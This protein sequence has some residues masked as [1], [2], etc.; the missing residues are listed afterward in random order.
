VSD[1]LQNRLAPAFAA[2]FLVSL[3]RSASDLLVPLTAV[4]QGVGPATI[5]AMM[6][7]AFLLPVLLAVPLGRYLHRWPP[8]VF[9]G[10]AGLSFIAAGSSMSIVGGVALMFGFQ[11]LTGIAHLLGLLTLQNY[12]ASGSQPASRARQFGWFSTFQS[13]GQFAGPLTAG[14]AFEIL[15]GSPSFVLVTLV[16]LLLIPVGMFLKVD[17]EG[18]VIGVEPSDH[19]INKGK[20]CPKGVTAYQQVNHPDRLL[21]PLIRDRRGADLHRASWDEALDRVASEI[22]RRRRRVR[23]R[24][25]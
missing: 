1:P 15:P 12:V 22:R 14:L 19:D 18:K 4:A 21:H 25:P 20:L 23:R 24:R 5:G 7:A 11:L 16:G 6:S 8:P 2:V 3:L 10:I 17:A 13:V 9:I